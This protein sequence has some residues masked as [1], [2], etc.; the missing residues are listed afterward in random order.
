MIPGTKI[1]CV[2]STPKEV[3]KLIKPNPKKGW[4]YLVEEMVPIKNPDGT[5]ETAIKIAGIK[6]LPDANGRF[7]YL[8]SDYFVPLHTLA[9]ANQLRKQKYP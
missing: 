7:I 2:E 9:S 4:V 6:N 8:A 5:F 1:L 3:R